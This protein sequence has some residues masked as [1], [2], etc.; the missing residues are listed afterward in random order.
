MNENIY[1]ALSSVVRSDSLQTV[2]QQVLW[3]DQGQEVDRPSVISGASAGDIP[4]PS[5]LNSASLNQCLRLSKTLQDLL[6]SEAL[7]AAKLSVDCDSLEKLQARLITHFSQNS[8]ETRI[9]Y[10]QSVL[11]WFFADGI[12]GLASRVWAAYQDEGVEKD[13]LRYLY[14]VAEPLM[15]GCVADALYPLEE[16]MLIPP[17]YFDQYLRN[18]LDEEP[19]PKTRD[20][21]KT[22][23]M[24]LGFLT[25]V[26]GKP[27]RLNPVIT[28]KTA[29]LIVFHYL[30]T[31]N[32]Q[33]TVEILRLFANPFWKYL[34]FKSEDAVRAV[35]R[36]ADVTGLLGKYVVA[37]QLEQVTTCLTLD[38]ILVRRLRL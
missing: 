30:F 33:R 22:N 12:S 37:D 14:L 11:R 9:R 28:T 35:L 21:L 6:L 5:A 27:D 17:N 23:L 38:E 29:F 4:S 7:L 8:Q 34:G 1:K 36:E 26:R 31:T 13:I 32:G 15:G 3:P 2:I 24:R 20:R 10:S 18:R 25:R 19:P 16:G